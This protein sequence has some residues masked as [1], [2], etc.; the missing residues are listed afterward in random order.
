[1]QVDID[2]HIIGE[3]CT[4]ACGECETPKDEHQV[5]G[6]LIWV[7]RPHSPAHGNSQLLGL[8]LKSR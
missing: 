3:G 8:L 6:M 1:V 7:T 4:P 5:V 2:L